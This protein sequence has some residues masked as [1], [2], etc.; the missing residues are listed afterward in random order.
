[1]YHLHKYHLVPKPLT[2]STTTYTARVACI[3]EAMA[4]LMLGQDSEY[5]VRPGF[6][7]DTLMTSTLATE[8]ITIVDTTATGDSFNTGYLAATLNGAND[9]TAMS[10][11]HQCSLHLIAHAGAIIPKEIC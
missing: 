8:S 7:G 10:A 11:G 4:E 2:M 3:G 9:Q 6:A 5:P 1:M